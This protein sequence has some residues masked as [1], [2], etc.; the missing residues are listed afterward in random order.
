MLVKTW[1][2]WE[3]STGPTSEEGKA[4]SSTNAHKHGARSEEWAS[5]RREL[6]ALLADHAALV[7]LA[8]ESKVD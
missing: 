8:V 7:S 1:K 6:L 3:Q 4:R 5:E 2:P